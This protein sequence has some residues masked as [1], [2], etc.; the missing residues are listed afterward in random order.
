MIL[1]QT[2]AV[3]PLERYIDYLK[4]IQ[5]GDW[6]HMNVEDPK[7][8]YIDN[9]DYQI[10]NFIQDHEFYITDGVYKVHDLSD[11]SRYFYGQIH[12]QKLINILFDE[13]QI[14]NLQQLMDIEIKKSICFYETIKENVQIVGDLL[15]D[16]EKSEE[17]KS[18]YDAIDWNVDA[19]ENEYME[20]E[21]LY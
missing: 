6:K 11:S 8:V 3:H 19:L 20:D 13:N 14:E 17:F 12:E 18:I 7:S 15:P 1:V 4:M 9:Y 21:E 2:F 16:Q 5:N 10:T